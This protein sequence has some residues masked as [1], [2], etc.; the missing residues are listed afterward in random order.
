MGVEAL[1]WEPGSQSEEMLLRTSFAELHGTLVEA[2]PMVNLDRAGPCEG[3]QEQSKDPQ[4]WLYIPKAI[5]V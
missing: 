3:K 4:H 2:E 5:R 1:A